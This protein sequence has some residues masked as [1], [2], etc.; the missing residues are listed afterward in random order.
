MEKLTLRLRWQRMTLSETKGV[1]NSIKKGE[2]NLKMK[3]A[4]DDPE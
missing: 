3:M 2:T 1:E 4:E